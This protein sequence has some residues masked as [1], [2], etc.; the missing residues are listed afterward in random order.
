MIE[1]KYRYD[2]HNNKVFYILQN[3]MSLSFRF[4]Y[5]FYNFSEISNINIDEA[6]W[7]ST[8]CRALK[9]FCNYNL[10]H[11]MFLKDINELNS[12]EETHPELF[13]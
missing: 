12:L 8:K 1:I 10:T 2:Y 5:G 4:W 7:K 13:I 11:F 3:D 9:N 6:E